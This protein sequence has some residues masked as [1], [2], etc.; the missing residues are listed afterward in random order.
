MKSIYLFIILLVLLFTSFYHGEPKVTKTTLF[1]GNTMTI[2]YRVIIGDELAQEKHQVVENVLTETFAH[3]DTVFNNWNPQAEISKFNALE[4]DTLFTPSSE[5]YAFLCQT[6]QIVHL[7]DGLFDPTIEPL[8]KLWRCHLEKG[9][10]PPHDEISLLSQAVGWEHIHFHNGVIFK[11]HPLTSID[12]GGIVKGHCVD[13]LVERLN[14][15]GFANVFVEWGGEIRTSGIHPDGRS[16]KIFI[17]NLGSHSTQ[18]AIAQIEMQNQAIATSGDYL[19][20]W[21]VFEDGQPVTYFHIIDPKIKRPLMVT[22]NSIASASVEA[23]TC[24]MADGIATALM[25]FPSKD[26]AQTWIEKIKTTKIPIKCWLASR[27]ELDLQN[28]SQQ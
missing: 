20:N 17:S 5:F 8:R 27:E 23:P 3:I 15:N 18:D 7:T 6:E 10:V 9:T 11:D 21:T 26:E 16:W 24:A 14:A 1:T 4:A 25:L 28:S 13:L 19:Q 2:D 22:R 12:L